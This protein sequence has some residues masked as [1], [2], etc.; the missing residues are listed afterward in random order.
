MKPTQD[1]FKFKP[2]MDC[3]NI[4]SFFPFKVEDLRIFVET[5][6]DKWIV[7]CLLRNMFVYIW[8]VIYVGNK[9]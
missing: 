1:T 6:N 9:D 7:H 5:W 3:D 2:Y 8:Y 4:P